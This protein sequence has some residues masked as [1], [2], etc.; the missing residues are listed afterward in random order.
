MVQVG[1]GLLDAIDNFLL[2]KRYLIL[3]RDPVCIA[4]FHRLLRDSGVEPLRLPAKSPN[5]N[6]HA[7][8]FVRSIRDECLDHV[9]L[10]GEGHLRTVVREY[11]AHY[12]RERNHQGIGNELIES[13]TTPPSMTSAVARRQRLGG[14]L[15]YCE[16]EA[17]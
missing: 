9:V 1:R 10:L 15:S 13:S 4:Q 16:R 6:A 3:D 2:G 8:R 12:H 17:A 5:L 7:E 14:L 11:V